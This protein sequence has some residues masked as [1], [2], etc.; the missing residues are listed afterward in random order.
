MHNTNGVV[1]R[2]DFMGLVAS[3]LFLPALPAWRVLTEGPR[4]T[5]RP[6]KPTEAAQPGLTKL[7]DDTRS[8]FLHVPK[9]YD[10]A[11]PIP[12]VVA[13]HGAGGRSA[14]PLRNWTPQADG[15]G[16]ALLVPESTGTTWDAIRGDYADD[17]AM[18]DRALQLVF[19]RVNIDP[20]R[21][22][23]QGFSDGASYGLGLALNN[24]DLFKRVVANSPGFITRYDRVSGGK[25][26]VF[27]SHGRQDS[28]LPFAN[29]VGRVV[30]QLKSAGCAVEFHEFEGG[31]MVPP[32]IAAQAAKFIVRV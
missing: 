7:W 10:P 19:D 1:T 24:T 27:V 28:I 9:S 14:G 31:H 8:A 16:F 23:L 21:V 22:V 32:D 2:R 13:L 11:T 25:P 26:A 20:R 6:H 29:A 15:S 18:I 30:P 3:S 4:L 5:A 17:V 12:L